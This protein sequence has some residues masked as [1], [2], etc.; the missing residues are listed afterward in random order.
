MFACSVLL[1]TG[2]NPIMETSPCVKIRQGS[3]GCSRGSN[4]QGPDALCPR[5]QPR[6]PPPSCPVLD[7]ISAPSIPNHYTAHLGPSQ[8]PSDIPR[9]QT[10]QRGL[11]EYLSSRRPLNPC[12]DPNIPPCNQSVTFGP[13]SHPR[14]SHAPR[15]ASNSGFFFSLGAQPTP[16]QR[17]TGVP[18][19]QI[20]V[21]KIFEGIFKPHPLPPSGGGRTPA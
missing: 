17:G 20:R 10:R 6:P 3:P 15:G 12:S 4:R 21:K 14:G 8:S 1:G 19:P 9:L 7:L 5:M 16:T 2:F 11:G 18:P 13:H